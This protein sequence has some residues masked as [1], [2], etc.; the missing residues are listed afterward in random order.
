MKTLVTGATGFIG[1]VLVRELVERGHAARALSM[2]GENTELLEKLGVE[3]MR[4]DL[5]AKGSLQGICDEVDIVFHCAARVTDWGTKKQ[6]YEA[7]YNT[8]KNLLE[9]AEGR[10]SRFVYISS[11]AALGLGHHLKGAKET[12][13]PK[14]SG[15]PYNDAKTD[16]EKSVLSVH[17]QGNMECVILRPANVTGPGSVWVRDILDR[18]YSIT[19]LPLIDSGK[20]SS[21][22]VYVDSLVDGIIRAGLSAKAA[23]NV[24]HFRDDWEVTW[25]RYIMDLGK[26]VGK[27]PGLSIPFYPA[28]VGGWIM[29]GICNLFHL[30]SPLTMLSAGVMGRNNDVDTSRAIEDLGWK[31]LVPYEEA[32]RR[33]GIWIQENYRSLRVATE[34]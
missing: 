31:T 1:S 9:E 15:V 12:D 3:I 34:K 30:R 17:E 10:A 21:S 20:H 18:F 23:G 11:I 2:E 19:G 25:K 7:I 4:G 28:W 6:F 24:Y 22:F 27:K 8:T 29:E 26:F 13:Q 16:T 14:K 5:T 33:T 32:M